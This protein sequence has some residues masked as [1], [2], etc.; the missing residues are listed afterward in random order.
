MR[1]ILIS[2]LLLFII[3][4]IVK[5]QSTLSR[6]HTIL[7]TNCSGSGCH[8]GSNP[9]LFDVSG[10]AND[11]YDDVV[12]IAAT[13]PAAAAKGNKL[14]DPGYPTRSFLLRKIAHGL[15]PDLALSQ[16]NEGGNMPS[17]R[18]KLTDAE[19]EMVR[20]WILF[21]APKTGTVVDEQLVID[22]Y[23]GKGLANVAVPAPPAAGEGFQ[24]HCGPIFLAPNAEKEFKWKYKTNITTTSE[25][26]RFDGYMSSQSH[27]LILYKYNQGQGVSGPEGLQQITSIN[28][29]AD[30]FLNSSQLAVWQYPREHLL[31]EGTSYFWEANP[32]LNSN[33]HVKNYSQDSILAAHSYINIYTKPAGSGDVQMFSDLVV[34]GGFNPYLLNVPNTGNDITL[35]INQSG[36][37]ETYNIW[38]LQAH[39]HKLGKKYEI[40]LRNS[41][42]TKGDLIYDG[43]YNED[44]TVNQGFYNYT[45][46]AVREFPDLFPV[47]M[48]TGLIH[49]ATYNNSGPSPVGFGLTTD[50]EMFITYMHYTKALPATAINEKS[51]NGI[52]MSVYPNPTGGEFSITYSMNRVERV[53]IS[54]FSLLGKEHVLL[55]NEQHDKGNYVKKFSA[56]KMNISSGIYF[57]RITAGNQS[58][59]RKIVI[60]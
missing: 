30:L 20:Q 27:H 59:V 42:G 60:E 14:V 39:T 53:N 21:G 13:N 24:V 23:N 55:Q 26:Y 15:S 38:I 7:Q 36:I 2:A 32:I 16:P 28:D 50:D 4:I 12:G 35:A 54:L 25:T 34:Y 22:Y 29:Q 47:D 18:P 49:E 8:G 45:H 58:S 48:N 1:T 43:N 3:P 41:D 33:F 57:V 6:V 40:Y 10:T 9:L 31:P 52:V 17:N 5:S 44:Y 51:K 46:P 56:E 37:N 11:F 19:I